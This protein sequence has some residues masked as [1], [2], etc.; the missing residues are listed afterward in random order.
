MSVNLKKR[1]TLPDSVITHIFTGEPSG[2]SFAGFHSEAEKSLDNG[3][4]LL[5]GQPD[6]EQMRRR[7]EGKTYK[8]RVRIRVD[9][10]FCATGGVST[11]FPNPKKPNGNRWT[12]ENIIR[13]IEQ[14]LTN[15]NDSVRSSRAEWE[16]RPRGQRGAGVVGQALTK[17]RVNG[18]SCHVLYQ[19]GVVASIY[20]ADL[21]FTAA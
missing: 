9:G 12:K 11:F 18:I 1:W 2:N 10:A 3:Q 15:P 14:G 7:E 4:L 19:N 8:L 6:P 13:W 21:D 17:I 20:P 16:S 5:V